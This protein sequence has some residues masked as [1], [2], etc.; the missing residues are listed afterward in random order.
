MFHLCSNTIMQKTI[1]QSQSTFLQTGCC[2]NVCCLRSHRQQSDR[3]QSVCGLVALWNF[4]FSSWFLSRCDC[5]LHTSKSK[6]L[7]GR[8]QSSYIRFKLEISSYSNFFYCSGLPHV[9][10]WVR[11]NESQVRTLMLGFSPRFIWDV[12]MVTQSFKGAR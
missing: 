5:N 10:P 3:I 2:Y 4:A 7:E 12:W 1:T 6:K 8:C 9:V 11:M